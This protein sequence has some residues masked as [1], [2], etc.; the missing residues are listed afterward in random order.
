MGKLRVGIENVRTR[1][2][3]HQDRHEHRRLAA[4]EDHHRVGLDADLEAL[5]E[6]GGD[7]LAQ[8]Q[9]ADRRRVPVMAVTQRLGRR[10]DDKI[11]RAEIG[12][13]DAEID[14]VAALRGKLHRTCEHG[15]RVFL[16]DAIESRDGLQHASA[17]HP[18]PPRGTS[19]QLSGQGN[20]H[21]FA[22]VG[23]DVRETVM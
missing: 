12:L 20:R 1:L 5:V 16:A 19:A 17:P 23:A 6:I 2:P 9:D 15:E 22:R 13:A 21:M 3:E 8:R 7:R 18:A 4:R 11:R 14:D 10:F